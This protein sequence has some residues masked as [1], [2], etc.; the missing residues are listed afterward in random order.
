MSGALN[1]CLR[2]VDTPKAWRG[3][4][5][6]QDRSWVLRLDEDDVADLETALAVAKQSNLAFPQITRAEFPL[7]DRLID[8]LGLRR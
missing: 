1:I 3:E 6:Q 2:Q 7:H 5:L 8:K 4:D